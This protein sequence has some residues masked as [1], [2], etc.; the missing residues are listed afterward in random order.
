M[1]RYPLQMTIAN[2]ISFSQE[3]GIYMAACFDEGKMDAYTKEING[4]V[5]LAQ[6][7]RNFIDGV[8]SN[9][10]KWG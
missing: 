3:G 5:S 2:L 6:V 1:I 10:A 8:K 9:L 7:F 4:R